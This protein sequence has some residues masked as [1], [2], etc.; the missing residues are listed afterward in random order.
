[1]ARVTRPL[2]DTEIRQAKP[3]EK[4]YNLAD[5][6]NLYLRV[7]PKN[8]KYWI[9]NY[10]RPGTKKRAN[11]SLG[12]YPDVSLAAARKKADELRAVLA[13]G[14]DPKEHREDQQRAQ[15][16]QYA[17]T[18]E[19]IAR[20]WL[21]LKEAKVSPAYY[22]KITGRLEKYIFP[23]MG[24]TPI[25][26]VTAVATI[27][28]IQPLANDEKLETVKKICR[29]V[30]EI[31]VYAVNTGVAH[32]NPLAGIGK[33]FSAPKVTNLPTLRPD[34]LPSL[35]YAIQHSNTK[36]VTRCLI[37][38]QLHTMV[39]PGEAAGA[40]WDEIDIDKKEWTIPAERMKKNKPHIVPLSPQL[41]RLLEV[42]RPVSGHREYVFPSDHNPRASANSQ[43]ANR[44]LARMGFHGR[45]VS[46]GLRALASTTLN[47]QGFDADAIEAA[48]AHVDKNS[49]RAAYNRAQYLE[50]R[51]TMMDWWSK[52]IEQCATGK[53]PTYTS[54]GHLSVVS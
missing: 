23:K 11:I 40:R 10:Y 33:A 16:E 32:A 48:L 46:H 45:L 41:L 7:H 42:L 5:G 17:N 47:E 27:E 22:D 37:E 34:E 8:G 12:T 52:H 43:S 54:R 3:R 15:N 28:I 36:L 25:H 31:M 2:T 38:W 30:N 14:I 49:I 50:R 9:L 19:H 29:W 1:M 6:K 51:R 53:M 26:K 35:M 20:K 21:T 13:E 44:A 4:E 18:F 39:R 24:R